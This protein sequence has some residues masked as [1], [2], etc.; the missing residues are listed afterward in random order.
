MTDAS[1]SAA[2]PEPP[3]SRIDPT[4]P[5]SARVWNYWLGGKDHFA[6]DRK[7]G[8]EILAVMPA[9]VDSARA[10]RAFLGRAVRHLVAAAG[11][12][13]F[14]DIGTGLPTADN[15]HEVA[16]SADPSCRVVYVDNDPIVLA[17]AR[18]LLVGTPEGATDY[19]EADLGAPE[20][21]LQRA[22]RTLDFDRPVGL[23]LLGILNFVCDTGQ[24]MSIMS[25]LLAPLASGSH[26]VIAHPTAQVHGEA[27]VEAVRRWNAAG[28]A[29][30]CLRTPAELAGFLEGLEMLPPGVVSCT[31]WRP[32]P[33]DFDAQ[34]EVSQFCAVARKL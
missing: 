15:T 27:M 32:A 30:M 25:R 17:H 3:H 29:R 20:E 8:D 16:Q 26:V 21:I 7:V 22:A 34:L 19:I 28:S 31:K 9:L 10:D 13:Q 33:D 6:S 24:A 5:H 1:S 2:G 11:V 23:M 18:A 14:L 12:R 4:L